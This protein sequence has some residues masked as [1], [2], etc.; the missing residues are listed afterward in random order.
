MAVI[1][2]RKI[3]GILSS[4]QIIINSNLVQTFLLARGESENIN[5]VILGSDW[6]RIAWNDAFKS[7]KLEKMEDTTFN[8][9]MQ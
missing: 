6:A 4:G 7:A 5:V 1:E 3:S 9:E 8:F 2:P